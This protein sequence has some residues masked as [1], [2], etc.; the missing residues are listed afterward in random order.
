LTMCSPIASASAAQTPRCFLRD[1]K[2][3]SQDSELRIQN[4]IAFI[5]NPEF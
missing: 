4:K 5:P 3:R 1:T 2:N